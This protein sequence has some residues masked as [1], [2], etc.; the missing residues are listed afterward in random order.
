MKR[1][2]IILVMFLNVI[3]SHAGNVN[4]YPVTFDLPSLTSLTNTVNIV[5]TNETLSFTCGFSSSMDIV[6]LKDELNNSLDAAN[7]SF[8][9]V[10][11]VNKYW[12]G[13]QV[14][15]TIGFNA[16]YAEITRILR[17]STNTNVFDIVVTGDN[18]GLLNIYTLTETWSP[19]E[20]DKFSLTLSGSQYGVTYSLYHNDEYLKAKTGDGGPLNFGDFYAPDALGEYYIKANFMNWEDQF[21]SPIII[22]NRNKLSEDQNYIARHTFTSKNG[23]SWYTDVTYYNGIGLPVQ[24]IQL[25]GSVEGN[26]FVKPISYDSMMRADSIDHLPFVSVLANGAF[27][28]NYVEKQRA[29][30]ASEDAAPYC[31]VE[32][33]KRGRPMTWQ[34]PGEIYRQDNKKVHTNYRINNG[35][36]NVLRLSYVDSTSS[37]YPEIIADGVFPANKLFVTTTINEDNDTS[38]VFK[39]VFDKTI[40]SRKLDNGTNHDTYYVYDIRDSLVCVIQPMG[41]IV[42]NTG[43]SFDSTLAK[44]YCFTYRY[45]ARGNLI[46]KSTPERGLERMFY[47]LRNR[48]VLYADDEMLQAQKYKYTIYD[49]LD[50]IAEEGYATSNMTTSSISAALKNGSPVSALIN[51][52]KITREVSFYDSN[53]EIQPYFSF[54][55]AKTDHVDY[56]HCLTLPME[57]TVWEAVSLSD[58]TLSTPSHYKKRRFFYDKNA[59]LAAISEFGSDY[60]SGGY[61]YDYLFRGNLAEKIEEHQ[62]SAILDHMKTYYSYDSRGRKLETFRVVN[63]IPLS[64]I[65]YE[66]DNFGNIIRKNNDYGFEEYEYNIQGWNTS[67]NTHMF[68][69]DIFHEDISYYSPELENSDKRYSGLVSEVSY[70]QFRGLQQTLSY[71]YDHLGRM[72][73]M[74]RYNGSVP[75]YQWVEKELTYDLNGN[76][77]KMTRIRNATDVRKIEYV[78]NG[79]RLQSVVENNSIKSLVYNSD[80][81]LKNNNAKGLQYSYNL[82]NLP[83]LIRAATGYPFKRFVYLSDGSKFSERDNTQAGLTYRGDFVYK[84]Q[85][86]GIEKLDNINYEEGKI[87]GAATQ[88]YAPTDKFIDIWHVKDYLG[89]VRVALDI[90]GNSSDPDDTVLEQNDYLPFGEKIANQLAPYD[91]NNRYRFGGKEQIS[92]GYVD[93]YDF[94]ARH[95]D[96]Y[97]SRWTTPDP[98]AEKYYSISPYSFCNSNPVNFIDPDG[99]DI[100][101]K[102]RNNSSV[103]IMNDKIDRVVDLAPLGVDWDGNYEIQG[104]EAAQLTLDLVGVFDPTGITD[105]TS[106]ILSL[107]NGDY[108]NAFNSLL[109]VVPIVGDLPKAGKVINLGDVARKTHKHHLIPKAVYRDNP[110]L[111][112]VMDRDKGNLV[113]LPEGFHWNHPSYSDWIRDQIRDMRDISVESIEELKKNALRHINDA[114]PIWNKNKTKENNMNSYFKKLN[115]ARQTK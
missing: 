105:I 67:R 15:I 113:E 39:D 75:V 87:Y 7:I 27:I 5:G 97:L 57:E 108:Q 76:I 107:K 9:R 40:L 70:H 94:G 38:Y 96:T 93:A 66:Y 101:L 18:D 16:L 99:L 106:S 59:R 103:V 21:T 71:Q 46:E 115:N 37:T 56:T 92:I 84:L 100:V 6:N 91:Q 44:R 72:T 102:G 29:H 23:R 98:H 81:N 85:D 33:D 112:K 61:S 50:R 78:L 86:E 22:K 104:E 49:D 48:M 43:F 31:S 4:I 12:Q 47:D 54:V 65:N 95:Y 32:Y 3:V 114:Y 24:E 19:T 51:D 64:S 62:S 77:R 82:L 34:R 8:A 41:S 52:K 53:I 20:I 17:I 79:N 110:E 26:N 10:M 45:D 80:G 58:T 36:E 90:T 73:D 13:N 109:G 11:N 28:P 35:T 63:D 25:K 89:N 60:W 55:K 42:I 83:E 1:L 111:Q 88:E 2:I 69:T 30:Y 68:G 74:S 14:N